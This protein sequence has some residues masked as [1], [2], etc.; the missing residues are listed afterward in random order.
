M[1]DELAI[2]EAIVAIAK[3]AGTKVDRSARAAR[4]DMGM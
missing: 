2:E 4:E 1:K 3:K